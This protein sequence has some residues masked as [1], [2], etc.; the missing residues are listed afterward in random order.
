ERAHAW[1]ATQSCPGRRARQLATPGEALNMVDAWPNNLPQ[2][3]QLRG[4]SI[5]VGDGLVEYDPDIG[6]PI[7]RRPT[8]AVVRPSAGAMTCRGAQ[9]ASFLAFL[10]TTIAGGALPFHFPD[11]LTDGAQV[12][13]VKFSKKSL[14]SIVPL[15]DDNFQLPLS[16]MV[17]P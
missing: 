15:G 17:L 13:L 1:C 10:D 16:L 6:P 3:L 8:T 7:T 11:P 9:M 12:L 5:G 14:T 2:A 4:A